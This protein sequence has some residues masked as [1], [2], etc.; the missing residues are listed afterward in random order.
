MSNVNWD[1]D[2][3]ETLYRVVQ[4]EGGNGKSPKSKA[5]GVIWDNIGNKLI[6]DHRRIFGCKTPE[7]ERLYSKFLEVLSFFLFLIFS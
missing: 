2:A 5:G 6:N 4:R 1:E 7:P 3:C